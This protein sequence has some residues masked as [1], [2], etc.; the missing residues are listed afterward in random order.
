M[1]KLEIRLERWGNTLLYQVLSQDDS[2]RNSCD[3]KASNGVRISSKKAPAVWKSEGLFIRGSNRNSDRYI[4]YAE[5]KTE[6][7]A[8]EFRVKILQAVEEFNAQVDWSKVPVDTKVLVRSNGEDWT[9]RYFA[10][11]EDGKYYCFGSGS[12]SWSTSKYDATSWKYC[13]LAE[14]EKQCQP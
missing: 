4:I 5:F 3:F 8:E 6:E 7:L 2:L 10:R 13:K 1:T 11:Y 9:R 12:T 14:E